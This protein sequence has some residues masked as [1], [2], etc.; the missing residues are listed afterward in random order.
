MQMTIAQQLGLSL[1]TVSNFFMNAR[2]RS[3]DKW[4]GMDDEK[5]SQLGQSDDE[6]LNSDEMMV[7]LDCA[8]QESPGPAPSL[9]DLSTT[10]YI[11]NEKGVLEPC[12]MEPLDPQKAKTLDFRGVSSSGGFMVIPISKAAASMSQ[13]S[14]PQHEDDNVDLMTPISGGD[15]EALPFLKDV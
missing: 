12:R 15:P 13:P 3:V 4:V 7:E 1:T 2:R 14:P 8:D 5:W 9:Q 6:M 10:V 11:T